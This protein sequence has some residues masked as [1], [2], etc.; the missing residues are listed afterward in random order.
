MKNKIISII[1]DSNQAAIL[2]PIP[3]P[4]VQHQKLALQDTK[5][6]NIKETKKNNLDDIAIK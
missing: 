1:G 5:A 2:V 3:K 4:K 6:K